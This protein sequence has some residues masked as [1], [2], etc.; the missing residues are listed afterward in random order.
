MQGDIVENI[1]ERVSVGRVQIAIHYSLAAMFWQIVCSNDA[2]CYNLF[3]MR[4]FVR[5]PGRIVADTISG[6]HILT[7]RCLLQEVAKSYAG[8]PLLD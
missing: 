8:M 6:V 1:S 3:G 4:V 5:A 7:E 2:I